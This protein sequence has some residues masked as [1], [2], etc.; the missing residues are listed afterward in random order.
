VELPRLEPLYQKYQDEGFQVIAVES[1]RDRKRATDFITKNKLTFPCL[2]NGEGDAEFVY[3]T[4]GVTGYPT[5]FL[6]DGKGRVLYMH[7]G[8]REGDEVRLE[9]EIQKVLAL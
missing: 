3:D 4:F 7:L 9:K 6:I 8:F 1:N 5:S 2:E